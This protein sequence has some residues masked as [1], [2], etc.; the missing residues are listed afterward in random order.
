MADA[1]ANLETLKK[2]K[3]NVV[4]YENV[5]EAIYNERPIAFDCQGPF[6]SDVIDQHVEAI[7]AAMQLINVACRRLA[8]RV[9]N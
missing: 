7:G 8:T 3:V 9:A 5:V 6:R 4:N 2:M 1:L